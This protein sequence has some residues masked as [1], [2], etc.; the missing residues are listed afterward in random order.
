MVRHVLHLLFENPDYPKADLRADGKIKGKT[1]G[2]PDHEDDLEEKEKGKT[3]K[4]PKIDYASIDWLFP[5]GI[6]YLDLALVCASLP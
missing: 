6:N 5:G 4:K 1:V 2:D 3:S